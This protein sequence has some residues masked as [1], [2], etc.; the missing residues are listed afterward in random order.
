MNEQVQETQRTWGR[1]PQD[2]QK[3]LIVLLG[4]MMRHQMEGTIHRK[5][6]TTR[7]AIDKTA[8]LRQ[9]GVHLKRGIL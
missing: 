2:Y 6:H 5:E 4:Q 3:Q 7:N 9:G 1:L 8:R